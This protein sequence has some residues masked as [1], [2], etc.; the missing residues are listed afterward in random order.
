M[1]LYLECYPCLLTQALKTAKL[2]GLNKSETKAVVDHVMRL[3]LDDHTNITAPHITARL[4]QFIRE[5]IYKG[6]ESFDPYREIKRDT[7]RKAIKYYKTLTGIV[8][9]SSS[10]L[11]TAVKV[12]AAGNII[13]FGAKAHGDIDIDHEINNIDNLEFQI[14]DFPALENK[15]KTAKEILYIGDNAGEIVFDR[16]LIA[17]IKKEYP[18]I[19]IVFAVREKPIINDVTLEDAE[20]A[21]MSDDATVISSGSI[22]PGTVLLETSYEF[23]RLF[24]SADLIIAKGQG[25][26]ETLSD[27]EKNNLYFLLRIKCD[28]V[29]EKINAHAGFLVLWRKNDQLK[30]NGSQNSL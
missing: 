27:V 23:Q 13:D 29:A 9:R 15:L 11:Q 16:I 19:D 24:S 14:F 26:Y 17:E 5:E 4:Y 30:L 3:L 25:N 2:I 18:E 22:Y 7:N 21:G 12:A 6:A 8:E 1:K 10:P 20:F 28:I